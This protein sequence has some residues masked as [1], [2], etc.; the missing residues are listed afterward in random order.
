MLRSSSVAAQLAA[1]QEGLSS[2][3]KYCKSSCRTLKELSGAWEGTIQGRCPS[4]IFATK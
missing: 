2:V 4:K 1:S 3:T